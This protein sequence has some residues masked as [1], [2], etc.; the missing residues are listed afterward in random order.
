MR[1]QMSRPRVFD[2]A[3][4]VIETNPVGL[5]TS[6]LGQNTRPLATLTFNALTEAADQ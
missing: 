5:T 4:R 3:W 2:L 1:P 6:I